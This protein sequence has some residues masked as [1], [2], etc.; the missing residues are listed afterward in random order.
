[1]VD[2]KKAAISAIKN[3]FPN[4]KIHGCFFHLNR[5]VWRQIQHHGLAKQYSDDVNFALEVRKLA[6]LAFIPCDK[7]I[8]SFEVLLESTYYVE[9][10]EILS[11]LITYFEGT[12]IGILNKRGN[13][14]PPVFAIE[15]WNCF[16]R[17]QGNLPGTNNKI[18]SWHNRFSAII[19][20]TK[21]II[22]KFIDSLKKEESLNKITTK[23]II[24]GYVPYKIKI[25]NDSSNRLL[26]ICTNVNNIPI[27][28][29]LK[30]I[31][32]SLIFINNNI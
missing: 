28:E 30:G 29:I 18:E 3:E 22:W 25:Y 23:Q 8:E 6:A 5:S 20:S 27:D 13:R 26:K 9:Y 21:L 12:W 17:L 11:L 15:T 14:R 31:A 32:H 7:V 19:S 10:E 2:F 16:D 4:T 24:A 1:M